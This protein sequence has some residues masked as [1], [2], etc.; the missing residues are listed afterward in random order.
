M[1]VMDEMCATMVAFG[2]T[3][4]ENCETQQDV[5]GVMSQFLYQAKVCSDVIHGGNEEEALK[6]LQRMTSELFGPTIN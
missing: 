1:I 5:Q 6:Y 3:I 2:N 4:L